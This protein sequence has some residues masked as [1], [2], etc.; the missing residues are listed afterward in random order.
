M[1]LES[2]IG[3]PK[4]STAGKVI[5]NEFTEISRQKQ[6]KRA[7]AILYRYNFNPL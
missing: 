3:V 6:G 1:P 2:A 7:H 5:H 4:T